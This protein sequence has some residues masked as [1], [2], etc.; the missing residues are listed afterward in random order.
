MNEIQFGMKSR[1]AVSLL[2]KPGAA[3]ASLP[4][5][6][7]P[8]I[9]YFVK[10]YTGEKTKP[11]Q[12]GWSSF[13][14]L[15]MFNGIKLSNNPYFLFQM[16]GRLI[17]FRLKTSTAPE[18]HQHLQL[19]KSAIDDPSTCINIFFETLLTKYLT[20]TAERN[21]EESTILFCLPEDQFPNF[22]YLSLM[23]FR[24]LQAKKC[25]FRIVPKFDFPPTLANLKLFS[26]GAMNHLPE[27][28]VNSLL[29]E[30]EAV[31]KTGVSVGH[32]FE[33]L[34]YCSDLSV[35]HLISMFMR[36]GSFFDCEKKLD[37]DLIRS[38]YTDSVSSKAMLSLVKPSRTYKNNEELHASSVCKPINQPKTMQNQNQ[39]GNRGLI[40]VAKDLFNPTVTKK[41]KSDIEASDMQKMIGNMLP[42]LDV[43][44]IKL[45]TP[46]NEVTFLSEKKQ[47][48]E[49]EIK[50][51]TCLPGNIIFVNPPTKV[52]P[53]KVPPSSSSNVQIL[54]I[55]EVCSM[56]T[57]EQEVNLGSI[58]MTCDSSSSKE[59]SVTLP[60]TSS[61]SSKKII[62]P[63][64]NNVTPRHI[65]P[66]ISPT[67]KSK[68]DSQ[69]CLGP[70][71]TKNLEE[72]I[73]LDNGIELSY[74]TVCM[75]PVCSK[76]APAK[77]AQA[78]KDE[79]CSNTVTQRF[80]DKYNIEEVS[81]CHIAPSL[82]N[83]QKDVSKSVRSKNPSQDSISQATPL[84]KEG[85]HLKLLGCNP[86]KNMLCR[87]SRMDKPSDFIPQKLTND[88]VLCTAL[89]GLKSEKSISVL[90]NS[91]SNSN[92]ITTGNFSSGHDYARAPLFDKEDKSKFVSAS[93]FA[94][95]S[96]SI[97]DCK[98][99]MTFPLKVEKTC[100]VI[101]SRPSNILVCPS[102]DAVSISTSTWDPSD[103]IFKATVRLRRL[104]KSVLDRAKK[105]PVRIRPSRVLK[106]PKFF[107]SYEIF[108]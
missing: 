26:Y 22:K 8:D 69:P 23:S 19:L 31:Y 54:S 92:S 42:N 40:R 47:T 84:S 80:T 96:S 106:K 11:Y 60:F 81:Y 52:D 32:F 100:T 70:T 107:A 24:N 101:E 44:N 98:E 41:K 7:E 46:R 91:N 50:K 34:Q 57:P 33:C 53:L 103:R 13:G 18:D 45:L 97:S 1:N 4:V 95:K 64:R 49:L 76:I 5:S 51:I 85:V 48:K 25:I 17:V 28:R 66:K 27:S 15:E 12:T 90:P 9:D 93:V 14:D 21:D 39:P 94:S 87:K 10:A 75:Q 6:T 2:K 102:L 63:M 43:K 38:I 73:L 105:S 89:S 99:E 67:L 74:P 62:I 65:K 37:L 88:G 3:L 82:I 36:T 35:R 61:N 108:D 78:S 72:V 55:Q 59:K 30:Q 77:V 58:P 83:L 104:D 20:L 16:E 79:S 29:C 71:G 86:R 68:S 56:P